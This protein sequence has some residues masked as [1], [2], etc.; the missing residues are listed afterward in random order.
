MSKPEPKRLS[1]KEEY[2]SLLD[3][4]DTF[5]FDCDG[6]LWSGDDLIPRA[7][8]VLAKLRSKGKQVVFVTNNASKSRKAYKGK[9]DKLSI[10]VEEV[11]PFTRDE[12]CAASLILLF[13]SSSTQSEIISSSYAAAAYLKEVLKF[14]LDRKV[15]VIGM[16]GIEEELDSVGI[17][18][19]GGTEVEDNK[20]LPAL[21]FSSLQGEDAIDPSVAAVMCGFDMNLNYIKLCKAFKY[22]TRE[23]AEGPVKSGEKGGGCYYICTN[24][25]STFPAK[26]GPWPGGSSLYKVCNYRS[27]S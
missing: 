16:H 7:K 6:V 15:Y 27:E 23:G 25:D 1:S 4:Y 17:K 18:H 14:P 19:C 2:T 26:G 10:P 5:L 20:F 21:D 13:L 8:E 3:K 12:I 22:I 24:I 11:R 9:F